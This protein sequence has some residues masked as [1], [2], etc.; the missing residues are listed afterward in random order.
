[1]QVVEHRTTGPGDAV[2]LPLGIA[3]L[4][5]G[6]HLGQQP[7]ASQ[8]LQLAVERADGDVSPEVDVLLLG[9]EAQLVPVHVPAPRKGVEDVQANGRHGTTLARVV[10]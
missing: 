7:L 8:P 1:M 10:L 9:Q 3:A 4:A 2:H 5:L 6:P